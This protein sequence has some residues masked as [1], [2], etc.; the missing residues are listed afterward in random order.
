MANESGLEGRYIG[1]IDIRDD[2]SMVDLP[3]GM[4]RDLQPPQ[5]CLRPRSGAADLARGW[6]G[7]RDAAQRGRKPRR[8]SSRATDVRA[9]ASGGRISSGAATQA[10]G[11]QLN[12]VRGST[13]GLSPVRTFECGV[14]LGVDAVQET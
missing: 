11:P 7:R 2:H 10:H 13:R 1:R 5:A 9:Q 4:P 6:L 8:R 3:E 14:G 12:R